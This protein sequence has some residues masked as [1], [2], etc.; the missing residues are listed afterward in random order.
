[1]TQTVANFVTHLECSLTG[2]RYAAGQLHNLSKAG[3]P[4]LVRYDS[5]Q[6]ARS[7]SKAQLAA[8]RC[9]M[10]RYREFLP[11]RN[12]QNVVSLGEV[13]TPLIEC[14]EL[15]R[16][17]GARKLMIKD[18]GRLPT[19]S[20]KAR[21][22]S[23][24]VS[25]AKELGVRRLAMPTNGNAGAALAAYATRAGMES[26]VF[27]PADTPAVNV[28]EIAAHGAKLWLV[29]GLIND[30]ARIVAEGRE[31]MGWFD[32]S[33][34]KE[35]YRIEGK[36]T[37]GLELADQLDWTLPDVI[38][39]PT[40]GGTG[41]IGMW[42]A[43]NELASIG[44]ID[45]KR[46]RMVAV[47]ASGCAPIVRA[48][49]EGL[50]FAPPWKDAHTVAA[51]IRV[52]A[53]IGDF[54]M[55]RA[56]HESN[57]FAIAVDDDEILGARDEVARAEGL[58]TCPESAATYAAYKNALATGRVSAEESVVLFNC[59]SGLKYELPT[60]N[61]LLDCTRTVDYEQLGKAAADESANI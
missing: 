21:G 50:D 52:P 51:G 11:L 1:V 59:A 17:H 36:K 55:L 18:E 27:C 33:T 48:F 49:N 6:L 22:L 39:Y 16:R 42:K 25:M 40:G 30:C 45:E 57:G 8:R 19:G 24:A 2:D 54:L 28:G 41:L 29:N 4:L 60:V 47:Q 31:Q 26:F 38:F 32:V 12:T 5:E 58:L 13:R 14:S 23:V 56:I 61:R 10:W 20:F 35:P 44:W 34:L 9:D 15:A 37:M 7:I 3:K 46:P 43:F 53:A